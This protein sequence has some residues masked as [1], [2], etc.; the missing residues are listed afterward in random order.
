[1]RAALGAEL[2]VAYPGVWLADGVWATHGHYLDAHSAA[3]SIE[4][5]TAAALGF[6]R[7]RP[8]PAASSPADYEAVLAP[9]YRLYFE[10]A[11]R[12]RLERLAD[13]GKALV[14]HVEIG[15][16]VRD[17]PRRGRQR[18]LGGA[19]LGT[20]EGELRRPG[21]L[22]FG[23]VLERL[24]IDA[25]HVLF[26][27]THRTGPLPGDR[28]ALWRT[29]AGIQLW[30]TGS[31]VDDGTPGEAAR[32]YAPGTVTLVEDGRPRFVHALG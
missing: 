27:H 23:A 15:L 31:W 30:N 19:R 8:P 9:T 16:G 4:C 6:V 32:G 17:G 29:R 11:Q 3:P 25:E 24:G 5:M 26:G 13:A 12:P 1:M 21:V 7:R 14:R 28:P 22:P 20:V 18:T 10:I 2:M